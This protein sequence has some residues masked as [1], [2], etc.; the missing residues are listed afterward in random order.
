MDQFRARSDGALVKE[1][2]Q[3]GLLG[4]LDLPVLHE[5]RKRLTD[6][7]PANVDFILTGKMLERLKSMN[8]D[9][10]ETFTSGAQLSFFHLEQVL[11]DSDADSEIDSDGSG[12]AARPSA[13]GE[14]LKSLKFAGPNEQTQTS[15]YWKA[16]TVFPWF[17][18]VEF[19][20]SKNIT[21]SVK[22]HGYTAAKKRAL[23]DYLDELE[24]WEEV[25]KQDGRW[26]EHKELPRMVRLAVK[27][28]LSSG[29]GVIDM[30]QKIKWPGKRKLR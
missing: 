29:F 30:F 1:N 20:R 6:E 26:S 28:T 23:A 7:S 3:E 4:H 19:G 17:F 21:Q 15:W 10:L 27:S 14:V 24:D 2:Y 16:K 9:E 11:G 25:L 12:D 22:N 8:A 18:S 5:L 13:L